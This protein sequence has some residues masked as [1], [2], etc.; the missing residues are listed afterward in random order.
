M[1]PSLV[2][3]S[4]DVSVH[5][6]YCVWI[7]SPPVFLYEVAH[8]LVHSSVLYQK[9]RNGGELMS[10][11]TQSSPDREVLIKVMFLVTVSVELS[12]LSS[13]VEEHIGLDP[14]VDPH[15]TASPF[16]LK[17][18]QVQITRGSQLGGI[19]RQVNW[20]FN[21]PQHELVGRFI[22]KCHML[23]LRLFDFI[24]QRIEKSMIGFYHGWANNLIWSHHRKSTR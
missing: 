24:L 23:K 22:L 2:K 14:F 17:L 13:L 16:N 19:G 1:V 4:R 3:N 11:R 21:V 20:P 7:E 5:G 9:V 12:P 18:R 10:H 8:F 15:A 6:V